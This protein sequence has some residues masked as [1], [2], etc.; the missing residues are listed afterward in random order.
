MKI[1]ILEKSHIEWLILMIHFMTNL[2]ILI[3]NRFIF[4]LVIRNFKNTQ[5]KVSHVVK[6]WNLKTIMENLYVYLPVRLID[7][8][9]FKE[10]SKWWNYSTKMYQYSN[11]KGHQHFINSFGVEYKNLLEMISKQLLVDEFCVYAP[12]SHL[13]SKEHISSKTSRWV[14]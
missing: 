4:L 2:N 13:S 3:L 5:Q 9:L 6:I 7:M 10:H 14:K 1:V 12:I 8:T 11:Q